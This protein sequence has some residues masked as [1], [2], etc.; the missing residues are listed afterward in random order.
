MEIGTRYGGYHG[1]GGM[2]G[3]PPGPP[4]GPGSSGNQGNSDSPGGRQF[5]RPAPYGAKGRRRF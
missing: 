2:P 4:R 5:N 1:F 3:N